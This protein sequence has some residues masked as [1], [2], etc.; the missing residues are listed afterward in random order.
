M[1]EKLIEHLQVVRVVAS[2]FQFWLS[3]ISFEEIIPFRISEILCHLVQ[4]LFLFISR[5]D[6]LVGAL[7]N[8]ESIELFVGQLEGEPHS[9]E[10]APT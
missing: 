8:L 4:D 10:V 1:M 7:L 2:G 5:V 9:G 6:V 3:E